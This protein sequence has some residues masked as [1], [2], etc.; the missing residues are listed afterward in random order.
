MKR[1]TLLR[2]GHAEAQAEGGDFER[3]LD[4]RGRAE[5]TRAAAALLQTCGLPDLVLTSTARRTQQTTAIVCEHA[6]LAVRSERRLYHASREEL[7]KVIQGTTDEITHLLVVGHNPGISELALRWANSLNPS[8]RFMG[9]STAGWC[10]VTFDGDHWAT[11]ATP[12]D[13]QFA[14]A[15]A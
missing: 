13:G 12:R 11:V 9:F 14:A 1:L 8:A 2:H 4:V 7:M 6:D 15:P 3:A 10:T 5:V